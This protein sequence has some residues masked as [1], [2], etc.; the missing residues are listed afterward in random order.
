MA[1]LGDMLQLQTLAGEPVTVAGTTVMPQSQALIIRFGSQGGFVWNRPVAV[2]VER[3]GLTDRVP[4]VDLTRLVQLT[5]L[6]A[7]TLTVMLVWILP[8]LFRRKP[9]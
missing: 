3:D 6:G 8:T 2:L 7:S 9:R 4:I 5:L 1:S